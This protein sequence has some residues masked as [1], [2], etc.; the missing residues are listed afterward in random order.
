MVNLNRVFLIGN[1]T[2]DPELRYA[3]S[4]TA[5]ANLRMAVNHQYTNSQGEKVEEASFF[6]VVVWG[7]QAETCCEYLKKG[8]A[9]FV[10]GRLRS[11]NWETPEGQKR[12]TVEVVANRV[13]FLPFAPQQTPTLSEDIEEEDLP[14]VDKDAEEVPF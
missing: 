3:P 5:V 12:S 11:R 10:E 6:N 9:V 2:K 13:Q 7:R 1:L 4:G 8:R 14:E